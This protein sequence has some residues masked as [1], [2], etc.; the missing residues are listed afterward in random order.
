MRTDTGLTDLVDDDHAGAVLD[1]DRGDRDA[2]DMALTI[3]P[4]T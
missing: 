2:A 4:P 1:R 3:A